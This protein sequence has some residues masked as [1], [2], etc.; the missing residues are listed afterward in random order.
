MKTALFLLCL[1]TQCIPLLRSAVTEVRMEIDLA[2]LQAA[3]HLKSGSLSEENGRVMLSQEN[4]NTHP[5]QIN[6]FRIDNPPLAF[7]PYAIRGEIRHTDVVGDGYLEMW[8]EFGSATNQGGGGR[9]F[10]RTLAEIG[11]MRKIKGSSDWR[12]FLV[13]FQPAGAPGAPKSLEFNLSLPGTGRVNL[14]GL[15]LIQTDGDVS[16]LMLMKT[17]GEWWPEQWTG[18]AGGALGG[19]LGCLGSAI[20]WLASR[21]KARAFVLRTLASLS[22]LGMMTLALGFVALIEKQPWHIAYGLLLLG[23]LM[24]G[25][26]ATQWVQHRRRYSQLELQKMSAMDASV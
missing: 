12:W 20:S 2:K 9:Y 25:I 24:A 18:L 14:R 7:K 11:P 8:N 5:V 6:L 1:C 17:P 21:G 23:F 4:T 13:P 16:Q 22:L 26:F 15:E 19:I 3:G 10:S